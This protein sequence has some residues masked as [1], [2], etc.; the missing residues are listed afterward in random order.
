[1]W[2]NIYK[3]Q[4]VFTSKFC[5]WNILLLSLNS[6]FF[7]YFADSQQ[8][9]GLG[10]RPGPWLTG[11]QPTKA[12]SQMCLHVQHVYGYSHFR[13]GMFILCV[14]TPVWL[15]A[16]SH[17]H[18]YVCVCRLICAPGH[19]VYVWLG[20]GN[21]WVMNPSSPQQWWVS[22][23]INYLKA[24]CSLCTSTLSISMWLC[25][26]YIPFI[27]T[28]Y[29]HFAIPAILGGKLLRSCSG[30]GFD[31]SQLLQ[32]IKFIMPNSPDVYF[33]SKGQKRSMTLTFVSLIK[34]GCIFML[35][36]ACCKLIPFRKIINWS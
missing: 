32:M 33:I 28:G 30:L 31:N 10:V 24:S 26:S 29:F 19:Y 9:R 22:E 36:V 2:N 17:S 25:T 6:I 16:A 12:N 14:V 35:V 7:I 20:R 27:L 15:C 18:W 4:H 8:L 1:M 11:W 3:F 23:R 34:N 5:H 21:G 13:Q